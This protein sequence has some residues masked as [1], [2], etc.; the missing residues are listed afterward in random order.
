[1]NNFTVATLMMDGLSLKSPLVLRLMKPYCVLKVI[2]DPN[3]NK[4]GVS[5]NKTS[6]NK[7]CIGPRKSTPALRSGA[8]VGAGGWALRV[9]HFHLCLPI[10][11]DIGTMCGTVQAS[12]FLASSFFCSQAES[13]PA[14]LPLPA[15]LFGLLGF[16]IFK[17]E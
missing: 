8:S 16:I 7:A 3:L 4:Y 1:M 13:T 5:G 10:P 14:P 15:S 9:R 12:I 17:I 6:P 2:K 11:K